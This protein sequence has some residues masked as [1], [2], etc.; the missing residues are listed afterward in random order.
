MRPV[1]PQNAPEHDEARPVRPYTMTGG[2]TRARGEHLPV[3]ALV[4][5]AGQIPPGLSP[6]KRLIVGL[7]GERFLSIAEL[8]AHA[9][10]PVGVVR[11]LV[12]DLTHDRLVTVHGLTAIAAGHDPASALSILESVLDGITA[13]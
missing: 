12:G 8:S 3:E 6:E 7:A 4:R 2:R 1:V 13:L 5:S 11:V 9:H 10:L